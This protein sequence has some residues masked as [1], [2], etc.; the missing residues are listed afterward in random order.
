MSVILNRDVARALRNNHFERVDDGTIFLP[1]QGISISGEFVH[2]VNGL[3]QCRDGNLIVDEGLQNLLDVNFNSTSAITSWFV[4][5]YSGNFSPANTWTAANVTS[6]S[7]EFTNYTQST[8]VAWTSNGAASLGPNSVSN[9]SSTAQFTINTGGG[10]V[11]GAFLASASAK[12]ATSGKLNSAA[13]F[14][15]SRTLLAADNLNIGY[16][17]SMTST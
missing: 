12:S 4:G 7:T 13:K 14:S 3:D 17:I 5:L 9:S 6:N 11:W 2:D 8:R 1:K 15:A 16:T 10:T